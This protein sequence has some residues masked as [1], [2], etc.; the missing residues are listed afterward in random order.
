MGLG[1]QT[2]AGSDYH[3]MDCTDARTAIS[4][5]LDGEDMP[6]AKPVLEAHLRSC[7][8]CR[9]FEAA[10]RAIHRRL[11]LR[12]AEPVPDLSASIVAAFEPADD[13]RIAGLRAGLAAVAIVQILVAL[14]ALILG[15]DAGLPA[16]TARHLGSF[17]V[18]LGIGFLVAA[19]RPER[20][21]GV[22]PLTAALV[23]CLLL[24]SALDVASSRANALSELGGHAT[25]LVGLGLLW[26]LARET[27]AA[28]L[29]WPRTRTGGPVTS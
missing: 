28:A 22:L 11:R 14:P 9:E 17:A 8:D 1:N 27:G 26:L 16:H 24:T 3:G 15:D 13:G 21:G 25:E 12:A 29:L 10:T 20:V 18:A 6:S 4:A 7:T 23:L 19:W 2:A 5:R